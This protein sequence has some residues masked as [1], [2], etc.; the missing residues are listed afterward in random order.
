[1]TRYKPRESSAALLEA[2]ESM[3]VVVLSGMRQTGKSTILRN[4]PQL[5]KRKYISFDDYNTLEIVRRAK[6]N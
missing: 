6:L 4:L 1:M 2:L 5:A 3:P